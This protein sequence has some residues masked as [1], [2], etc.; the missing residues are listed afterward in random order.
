MTL[1]NLIFLPRY[2]FNLIIFSQIK[3]ARILYYNYLKS[4][5]FKKAKNIIKFI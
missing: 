1:L 4:I 2:N 5:I 3:K